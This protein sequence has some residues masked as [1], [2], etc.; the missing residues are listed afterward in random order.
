[1][2]IDARYL[3][4]PMACAF[5][6]T[7]AAQEAT[8]SWQVTD[9]GNGDGI[10]EPGEDAL[11]TLWGEMSPQEVGFGASYFQIIGLSL[12]ETGTVVSYDNLLDE[13]TD[14][15][16]LLADGTITD[17]DAF[18]M[19]PFFNPEFDGSNPIPIYRIVWAPDSYAD[20]M[21]M[22]TSDAHLYSDVYID[23]YGSSIPYAAVTNAAAFEIV[24][25]PPGCR[26]LSQVVEEP[27]GPDGSWFGR[28]IA[29]LEDRAFVGAHVDTFE[30][31]DS[32]TVS[33][34]ER[35]IDGSWLLQ[36]RLA[37]SAPVGR[38]EFGWSVSVDQDLLAI[39][40]VRGGRAG[41][42]HL[43]NDSSGQW[44][45]EAVI[46]PLDPQADD[47]FGH[48]TALCR[49]AA[50]E[51]LVVGASRRDEQGVTDAGCAYVFLQDG[52]GWGQIEPKLAAPDPTPQAQFG[53]SVD[54]IEHGGEIVIAVGSPV[55][56]TAGNNA[57]AVYIYLLSGGVVVPEDVLLPSPPEA[58]SAF[59]RAMKLVSC[60]EDLFC[61]VGAEQAD[62]A[63]MNS[64]AVYLY[65]RGQVGW[66]F[67]GSLPVQGI[68]DAD[69]FGSALAVD[70]SSGV[71][72]LAV[73]ASAVGSAEP[74]SAYLFEYRNGAWEQT[75]GIPPAY[76]E[77]GAQFGGGVAVLADT[78]GNTIVVGAPSS[79]G[80][81]LDWGAAEF[82]TRPFGAPE[83][84]SQPTEVSVY[85]WADMTLAVEARG[86]GPL[87]IQWY[88]DGSP[89]DDGDGTSGANTFVLTVGD[90]QVADSGTY[91]VQASGP[92]GDVVSQPITVEVICR[93][94]IGG[95]GQVNTIDVVQF[96]NLWVAGDPSVD[97]NGDGLINSQD[98]IGF[99]NDW[100]AG[101]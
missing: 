70:C 57:G 84:I 93:A 45:E 87:E 31:S 30:G 96:L 47:R 98:V 28:S 6:A 81:G 72:T 7:A 34:F 44:V 94:D 11:L 50:G 86:T 64:G 13:Y 58:N 14:D 75:S 59:G 5:V 42:V 26:E 100:V 97:W 46:Q 12:W 91:E 76:P 51:I 16:T 78:E 53:R 82:L 27:D 25:V 95:D 60:G 36:D 41:A 43:F 88:K 89:V 99:L 83:V 101:C 71:P 40:A 10:I 79:D 1:M 15:G 62:T 55:D 24:D 22:L 90:A 33:L 21:V 17:I 8:Y 37:P 69:H 67:E 85:V 38:D 18:Q 77:S 39:G 92:C 35:Q 9:T 23:E 48:A 61:V 63:G 3:A 20:R 32:G 29:L 73:G 80:G 56:D 65:R 74:G 2:N 19:P 49:S 54:A 68:D 52:G 4:W 66:T